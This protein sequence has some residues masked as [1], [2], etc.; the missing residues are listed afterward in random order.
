MNDD[1]RVDLLRQLAD[2]VRLR[3]VDTLGHGG[4]KTPSEMAARM[5]LPLPLLSNHLKRLRDGGVVQVERRGRVAIYSLADEG[6]QVLLPVLDRITGRLASL[7]PEPDEQ[8]GRTCYDHL[9]GRLGVGLYRALLD[10]EAIAAHADGTVELGPR[11]EP[12]ERLGVDL[13]PDP[14][15]RFAFECL[16]ASQ[17]APH[18]AGVLGDALA[19]ALERRGW[20]ERGA[21]RAVAVTP[22]GRRGLR[23]LGLGV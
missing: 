14:R 10:R 5:G 23:R 9:A 18:L 21:Q 6:L 11:P 22:A 8:D 20:I 17:H 19:D 13:T 16:D 2:P 1:P 12:L 15:R 7:P 4:P 3:I